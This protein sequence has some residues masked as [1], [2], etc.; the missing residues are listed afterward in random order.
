MGKVGGDVTDFAV[1]RFS[2]E[3]YFFHYNTFVAIKNPDEKNARLEVHTLQVNLID[4]LFDSSYPV[5]K[6]ELSDCAE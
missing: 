2:H 4:K 6:F 1:N 5:F 3:G